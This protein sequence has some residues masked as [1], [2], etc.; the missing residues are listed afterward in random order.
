MGYSTV[1]A[2]SQ[3]RG[4]MDAPYFATNEAPQPQEDD[5]LGFSITC[6]GQEDGKEM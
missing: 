1:F 5:E 6:S 2:R 3:E 4:R